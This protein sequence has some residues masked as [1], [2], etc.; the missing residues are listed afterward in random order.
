[1]CE[2]CNQTLFKLHVILYEIFTVKKT[3]KTVIIYWQ[4]ENKCNL[5]KSKTATENTKKKEEN[6]LD[7]LF[8]LYSNK[9]NKEL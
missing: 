2:N 1:M 5:L 8:L 6:I 3:C 4:D 7:L 9:W